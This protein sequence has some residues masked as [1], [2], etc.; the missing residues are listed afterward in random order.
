MEGI[1]YTLGGIMKKDKRNIVVLFNEDG[2]LKGIIYAE[3]C[4]KEEAESQYK[5]TIQEII[6]Y[7]EPTGEPYD[8]E[9]LSYLG[10][11]YWH[12]NPRKED[13]IIQCV[14][15]EPNAEKFYVFDYET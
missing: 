5:K 3:D 15:S 7:D 13:E 14:K 8:E 9:L 12:T 1:L 11:E 6:E 4:T 10:I 2:D